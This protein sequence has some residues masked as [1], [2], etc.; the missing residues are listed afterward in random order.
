MADV[1]VSPGV[2][3]Q[4]IDDTFVPAGAGTIGAA[5]IGRTASGPAFRPI[6]VNNFNEFNKTF[7][8]LSPSRYMPY[9][10][11]AYL[12]N[13]SP[14]TVVRVL[15]KNT[16]DAG[17]IGTIAFANET[18][19]GDPVTG[20]NASAS[21]SS[22]N[23]VFATVRR[24]GSGTDKILMSG[25]VFNFSI[26][27]AHGNTPTTE[28]L[29]EGLS[30]KP[31]SASYI[32]KVLGTAPVTA[33]SGDSLTSL[34]VD[35]VFSYSTPPADNT[36]SGGDN[37][38]GEGDWSNCGQAQYGGDQFDEVVGGFSQAATP[39]IVSQNFNGTVHPLFKFTTLSDGNETNNKYKVS[40]SHVDLN[41]SSSAFPK[42]TVSVR[43]ASDSDEQPTVLESFSDVNLDPNNK[44]SYQ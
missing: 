16:Q 23:T 41:Q 27:S 40:I 14:L 1:F 21:L 10:A 38:G 8:G 39:W 4:E 18:S 5:L 7:G 6:R 24:R 36:I 30:L 20:Q 2:Y 26:S 3:T 37:E 42:F 9:A 13:G 19:G 33:R 29:V 43:L 35:S 17:T 11:K 15:G 34:Y 12:R 31:E 25:S 44:N 28:H 22:S 32:G